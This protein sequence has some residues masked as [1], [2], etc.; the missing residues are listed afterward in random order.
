MQTLGRGRP[1]ERVAWGAAG[2]GPAADKFVALGCMAGGTTLLA[3][4][5]A[6]DP[7]QSQEWCLPKV[8]GLQVELEEIHA[9]VVAVGV[10][11]MVGSSAR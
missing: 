1:A 10:R 2:Q 7:G 11:M 3:R 5:L 4:C 9:V 6:D 8:V